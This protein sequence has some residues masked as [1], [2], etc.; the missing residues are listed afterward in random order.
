MSIDDFGTGYSSLAYLKRFP[1]DCLKIDQ[2]FVSDLIDD[3]DD[4]AIVRAVIQLRTQ[5]APG[6]DRR[7]DGNHEQL[8]VLRA[9]GCLALRATCSV[10]HCRQKPSA[11][12]L[13]V[14]VLPGQPDHHRLSTVSTARV[15]ANRTRD[16]SG[17]HNLDRIR[18]Q[19]VTQLSR[20][21]SSGRTASPPPRAGRPRPRHC[22]SAREQGTPVA[23][24]VSTL[25][26]RSAAATAPGLTHLAVETQLEALA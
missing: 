18:R 3:P 15:P 5:P 22:D 14:G 13:R 1:V 19:P 12:S 17:I 20:R 6:C 8:D 26:R 16:R 4:A 25:C 21:L 2:S 9:E 23:E 10:L 11:T 24:G 7:G